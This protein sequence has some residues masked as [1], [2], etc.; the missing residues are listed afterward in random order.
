MK[1]YY[2]LW[3]YNDSIFAM[4]SPLSQQKRIRNT[5]ATNK[6]THKMVRCKQINYLDWFQVQIKM[7]FKLFKNYVWDKNKEVA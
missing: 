3:F 2:V 1:I 6:K 5:I 4:E 7:K